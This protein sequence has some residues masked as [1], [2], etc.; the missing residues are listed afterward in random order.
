MVVLVNNSGM[1]GDV[2]NIGE[3]TPENI[4]KVNMLNAIAP[5]ILTNEFIK[6]Y[7]NTPADIVV[8]N[9]SSGAARHPVESWANYCATKSSLDMLSKVIQLENASSN[10]RVYSVAPG[11]VD[12]K[13]QEE[14][15]SVSPEDFPHLSKFVSYKQKN[16]LVNPKDVA[17]LLLDIIYNPKRYQD[18][19]LDLR[20]I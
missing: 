6:A 14:I 2:K 19:V 16:Q 18:V 10:I 5:A 15:R 3:Q 13:M 8:L 1:L 11:V 4:Y 17:V 7:K 12:T 9:I 20:E